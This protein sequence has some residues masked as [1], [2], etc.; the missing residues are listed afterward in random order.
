MENDIDN[1]PIDSKHYDE[2]YS[3]LNTRLYKMYDVILETKNR[4]EILTVRMETI[5][6]E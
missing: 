6:S 1:L 3:D 4:I 2:M 5:Q